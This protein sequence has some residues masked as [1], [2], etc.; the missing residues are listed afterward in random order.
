MDI[1]TSV[2]VLFG[3]GTMIEQIERIHRAGFTCMDI[4]FGDWSGDYSPFPDSP[5]VQEHWEDWIQDIKTY[6][7]NHGITYVQGHAPI[8]PIFSEGEK[9]D[10]LY[11][12]A[13][14]SIQAAAM[15][16]IPWLVFHA[17]TF[18][19]S[20]DAAHTQA[21]KDANLRW[22][23]PFVQLAEDSGI[24]IAIENMADQFGRYS[25]MEG[26]YT[27][28]T[29]NLIDLVDSLGSP[30]VGICW[31]TGHAHI[32]GVSQPDMLHMI[33][34]RLKAVHIQDSNG[35]QDQHTAPF[36]GT[37]E[38]KPIMQALHEIAFPGPFTFE[39][40]MLI[41]PV[42]NTCKDAALQLLYAI[43]KEL[44]SENFIAD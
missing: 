30:H 41:R 25:G 36:Y 6:G 38:W 5:F 4:N 34:S 40:H 29:E 12:Q 42:P 9:S 22:F 23:E 3:C 17:G 32:Q 21:L 44:I 10:H 35:K 11:K 33:G 43:G 27:A 37:I 39:S 26:L 1:A 13:K 7:Q 8:Y 19:G 2:N 16:D 20:F 24:G 31:D 15:L 14:R 18:P 28:K